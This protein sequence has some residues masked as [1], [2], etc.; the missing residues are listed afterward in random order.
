MAYVPKKVR[1]SVLE[2][3]KYVCR[4]CGSDWNTRVHHIDWSGCA[5]GE[6]NNSEDNLIVLCSTCHSAAHRPWTHKRKKH[7]WCAR[8]TPRQLKNLLGLRKGHGPSF[9][10]STPKMI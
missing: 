2:R 1:D 5:K 4:M 7:Y 9:Q 3:D 8:I 10:Y 6:V